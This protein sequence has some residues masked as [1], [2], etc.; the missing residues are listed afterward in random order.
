MKISLVTI[1]AL[2]TFPC[3]IKHDGS[4]DVAD[5]IAIQC[6]L[7]IF[8]VVIKSDFCLYNSYYGNF[9]QNVKRYDC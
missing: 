3:D 5:A 2:F 8:D 4:R 9:L 6:R 1:V 7:S